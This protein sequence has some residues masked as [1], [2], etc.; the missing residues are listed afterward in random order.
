MSLSKWESE[1]TI[2][3]NDGEDEANIYTCQ[4]RIMTIMV[5]RGIEATNQ[6][7]QNGKVIAY[8]Y[9][10]PKSWIKISPPR[11]VSDKQREAAR[12]NIA[13]LLKKDGSMPTN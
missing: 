2:A 7:K 6:F 11:K 1:T 9:R 5:K 10:V 8:T 13:A 4:K 3:F 12:R